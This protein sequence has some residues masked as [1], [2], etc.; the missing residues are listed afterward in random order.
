MAGF[1]DKNTRIVDVVLTNNGKRLLSQNKLNFCYWV[2]FDD[3]LDYD[4]FISGSAS[5]SQEQ[6]SSSV[7]L[8]IETTP[9]REAVSGYKIGNMLSTDKTNVNRPMFTMA[10]GQTQLPQ[11]QFPDDSS[12]TIETKQ[13]KVSIVYNEET[14]IDNFSVNL[15]SKDGGVERFDSTDFKLDLSY[16]KDSFPPDFQ[17]DG[18]LVTILRSG[19]EGYYEVDSKRDMNNDLS[20]GSDLILFTGKNGE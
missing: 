19:S 13:R 14:D 18:F 3:E 8:S 12:R 17:P 4:P 9:I 16:S 15:D 11:A 5:L 10:Q 20:Y 6:L 2:P 1:L 7:Y